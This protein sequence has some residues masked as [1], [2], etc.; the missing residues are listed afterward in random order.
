MPPSHSPWRCVLY[1]CLLPS[2][3]NP[4]LDWQALGNH[5]YLLP[6]LGYLLAHAY[7][8]F[9]DD[10]V[11]SDLAMRWIFWILSF[12]FFIDCFFYVKFALKG[13]WTKHRQTI[14]YNSNELSDEQSEQFSR[15]SSN[16]LSLSEAASS[17][18][19]AES[20]RQEDREILVIGD[21]SLSDSTDLEH[22]VQEAAFF[23]HQRVT[24]FPL[25]ATSLAELF[26]VLGSALSFMSANVPVISSWMDQDDSSWNVSSI[27]LDF[28]SVLSFTISA[29]F[30]YFTWHHY[31]GSSALIQ[32]RNV[33]FWAELFNFLG[34]ALYLA[35]NGTALGLYYHWLNAD[36]STQLNNQLKAQ[37]V[38]FAG[39]FIYVSSAICYEITWWMDQ[40]RGLKFWKIMEQKYKNKGKYGEIN[41]QKKSGKQEMEEVQ[42]T[43]KQASE[44][45]EMKNTLSTVQYDRTLI[46]IASEA[47]E[48][49]NE[50]IEFSALNQ[51]SPPRTDKKRSKN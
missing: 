12:V 2:P 3:I 46:A 44:E 8:S 27:W 7:D 40:R 38:S 47:E 36:E 51:R 10:R 42:L 49:E 37:I 43:S 6:S 25:S 11:L 45:Q 18:N 29:C 20:R 24:L 48:P 28:F 15:S 21:S 23:H 34:G 4:Q 31:S 50:E 1:F 39:D 41:E 5:F 14:K 33:G 26:N 9:R 19:S 30:Y 32:V 22:V 17:G 16:C 35:A 13:I